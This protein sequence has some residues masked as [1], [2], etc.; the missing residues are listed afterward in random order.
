M[1]GRNIY[2]TDVERI[3][4]TVDGVR[5]GNAVAV[6]W[7]A[8]GGRESFALAVESR[9]ADDDDE[10]ER[11]AAAVRS[12]VTAAIGVRPAVVKVVPVG[13]LPKTPSGKLKRSAAAAI[14]DR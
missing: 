3:A 5:A 14:I 7:T 1:G 8:S 10:A 6:R 4:E 2:P 13:S 11:I 9:Q 12:A